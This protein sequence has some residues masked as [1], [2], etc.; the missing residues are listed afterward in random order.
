MDNDMMI[1]RGRGLVDL[2]AGITPTL[3]GWTVNPT[4]GAD[5]TD[6]DISTFCTTGNKVTGGGYQYAYFEWDLGAFYNVMCTGFGGCTS[7]GSGYVF[8]KLWDGAAWQSSSGRVSSGSA[9]GFVAI[10]FRCSKVRL[11]LTSSAAATNSPN[12]REFNVWRL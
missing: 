4:D 5:I 7:T 12:I 6:G 9:E 10:G 8:Y 3:V 2:I 1:Q 11:S